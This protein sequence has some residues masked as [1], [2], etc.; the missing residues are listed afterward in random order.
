MTFDVRFSDLGKKHRP[1]LPE[2]ACRLL[3]IPF[4]TN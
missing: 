3:G 2:G 1:D 4:K